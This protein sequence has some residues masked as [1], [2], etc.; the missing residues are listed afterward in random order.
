MNVLNK[1]LDLNKNK[2][3]DPN[4]DRLYW[5]SGML[6]SVAGLVPISEGLSHLGTSHHDFGLAHLFYG[7]FIISLVFIRRLGNVRVLIHI[8]F[9]LSAFQ[10]YYYNL[11][12]GLGSGNYIWYIPYQVAIAFFFYGNYMVDFYAEVGISLLSLICSFF[13]PFIV[14]EVWLSEQEQR[15]IFIFNVFSGLFTVFLFGVFYIRQ[16]NANQKVITDKIKEKEILLSEVNHR[17]R[18]NLNVIASLLKLQK[19]TLKTKEAKE[20]FQQASLRVHSMAWVHNQLYKDTETGKI[21]FK[22]YIE[23]LVKEI[24][25]ST[26]I[27]TQIEL[28]LKVDA[29]DVDVSRAIP[30]GQII[31]ELITNSIKHA[32]HDVV[33]P[34][35]ECI[36]KQIDEG[37]ELIYRD[38]G[39]G[40]SREEV[41][42][43]SLGIFLIT[44]LCEQIDGECA[45]D[46]DGR[47]EYH[48]RVKNVS[49]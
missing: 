27:D 40:Y 16:L 42:L 30:L 26:G 45:V 22:E 35:I 37:V 41:S 14:D 8:A 3:G 18:N 33:N 15:E 4:K 36:I 9:V 20:A 24:Q 39:K 38:N 46:T 10:M 7:I 2:Y 1:I 23:N 5:L 17:V 6:F 44:S 34:K 25:Y 11:Y 19:E 48:L 13:G 47:F 21:N 49:V 29:V 12:F 32:F 43:D 28:D 31:N